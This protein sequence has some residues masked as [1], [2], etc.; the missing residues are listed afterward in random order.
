MGHPR[1]RIPRSGELDLP[2][3][4]DDAGLFP[5]LADES[6][7]DRL[8]GFEMAGG[9]VPGTVLVAGVLALPEE[10]LAG[11]V[12]EHEVHVAGERVATCIRAVGGG[13]G[14]LRHERTPGY[15][16]EKVPVRTARWASSS[17]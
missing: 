10:N 4:D 9:Q 11:L 1:R 7:H 12:D 13:G 8:A 14:G 5:G 3:V 6:G 16:A 17:L 2:R 15:G